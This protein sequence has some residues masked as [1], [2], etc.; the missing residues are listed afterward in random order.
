MRNV[1]SQSIASLLKSSTMD[2]IHSFR[3]YYAVLPLTVSSF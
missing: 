3:K 2:C 1:I